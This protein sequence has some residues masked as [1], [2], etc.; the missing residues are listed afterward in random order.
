MFLAKSVLA[1]NPELYNGSYGQVGLHTSQ[2]HF[3]EPVLLLRPCYTR[4]QA[5]EKGPDWRPQTDHRRQVTAA[6]RSSTWASSN[7]SVF[8][9]HVLQSEV[10]LHWGHAPAHRLELF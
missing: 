9:E 5:A 7:Q 10:A 2:E 4:T 8:R 3:G 6:D 1:S